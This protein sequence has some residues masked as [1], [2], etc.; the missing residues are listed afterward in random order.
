MSPLALELRHIKQNQQVACSEQMKGLFL[1]LFTQNFVAHYHS[2]LQLQKFPWIQKEHKQIGGGK[3]LQGLLI[4]KIKFL[5]QKMPLLQIAGGRKCLGEVLLDEKGRHI[6]FLWLLL[7]VAGYCT[8]WTLHLTH[9]SHALLFHQGPE[10]CC[11]YLINSSMC[12]I[13]PQCE[14]KTGRRASFFLFQYKS[15]L[16]QIIEK[17]NCVLH[18]GA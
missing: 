17:N 2:S 11:S 7:F 3:C 4:L 1:S 18:L 9:C 6:L 15:L 5:A 13:C 10:C 14:F 16:E 12:C 8:N